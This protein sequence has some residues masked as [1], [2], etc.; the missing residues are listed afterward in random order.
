MI[1]R[2]GRAGAGRRRGRGGGAAHRRAV[3][4]PA[5][6]QVREPP[7][8]APTAKPGVVPVADT[9]ADADARPALAAALAPVVADPNL[10]A[11]TGRITDAITGDELWQQGA[12][13]PMQP[14]S[15]NKVL[16]TRRGAADA[17]PQTPG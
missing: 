16:T 10:G 3:A 17:R 15:T 6:P 7:P 1:D 12:D 13:V 8:R 14:A 9:A 11:L 2:G 4:A 5:A